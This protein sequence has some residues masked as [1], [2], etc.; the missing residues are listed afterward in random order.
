MTGGS[1]GSRRRA[2]VV[3]R[4]L[5]RRRGQ[6][7]PPKPYGVFVSLDG[8]EGEAANVLAGTKICKRDTKGKQLMHPSP[9][10]A[11]FKGGPPSLQ[12]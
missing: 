4:R 1:L 6:Y 5:L 9:Q 2:G 11:L 7:R 10:L 3:L 12:A 8:Y